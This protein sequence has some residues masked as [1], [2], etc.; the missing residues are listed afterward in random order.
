MGYH[1]VAIRMR[2][3]AYATSAKHINI[4]F[5]NKATGKHDIAGNALP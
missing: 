1:A 2:A 3:I 4:A 5:H